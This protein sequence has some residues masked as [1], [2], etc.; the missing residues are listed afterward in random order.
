[1]ITLPE[2]AK[3]FVEMAKE[4]GLDKAG[5]MIEVPAAV[6]LADE[7]TKVCHF[8]SIGTNDLGQYLHAADRESAALAGFNDPWQPALLRAV[9]QI[10][11]A[12]IKNNCPVGVCGEAASDPTL[13]SV[14]VGMGVSSLSSSVATLIDVAQAITAHSTLQLTLAGKAAV[15]AKTAADAKNSA[16]K[17]LVELV[18]LGL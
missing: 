5:V 12:G 16:R 15:A 4:Y 18:N 7:I 3:N 1:M 17:E 9:H 8:V 2:E 14:L 10:A 11:Q 13:A 6:F